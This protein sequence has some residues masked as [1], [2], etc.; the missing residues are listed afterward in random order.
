MMDTVDIF[1]HILFKVC[2][3]LHDV[4]GI[5]FSKMKINMVLSS[6]FKCYMRS[7]VTVKAR[8]FL[9]RNSSQRHPRCNNKRV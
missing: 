7:T 8:P 9:Y 4:K 3:S 6:K 2:T 1:S 5:L